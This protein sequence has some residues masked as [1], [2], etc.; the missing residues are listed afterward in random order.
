LT[1]VIDASVAL[2]WF[3]SEEESDGADALFEAFLRNRIE[4]LAPDVLL[5]EVANALWKQ[6][7]ILKLLRPEDVISIFHDFV[8]LPLNLQASNPLASRALELALKFHH[9]IYDTLYCALAIENDCEFV[10]ADKVLVSKLSGHLP[11]VRFL[12]TIKI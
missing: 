3:L 5:L 2:K 9:P 4:L 10:T 6:T 12:S 11:F 1:Y 8:T 7:A